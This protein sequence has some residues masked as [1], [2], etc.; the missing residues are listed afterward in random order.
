MNARKKSNR[1]EPAQTTS[2]LSTRRKEILNILNQQESSWS[3]C[4]LDYCGNHTPDTEL[5][6]VLVEIGNT[7]S[8]RASTPA[9]TKQAVI[10]ELQRN[11]EYYLNHALPQISLSFSRVLAD[12]PE[13]FSL[14]LCH[15]LYE[16]FEKALIEHIREEEHDFQAFN[17]GTKAG[18]DCFHA[19]HDETAALDQ[20][21]EMLSECTTSKSFDPCHILVLR[22]Q[23]LS[24]D[25]KI[26]TFV[27]EKLLMPMLK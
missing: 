18:P 27:E 13:H 3:Q 4:V 24:N 16:V 17:K 2:G 6:Q 19:H 7:D 20:I 11:H 8:G 5:L 1:T 15:T 9:L 22:L 12:R 10:A 23:N 25:L 14:H 21:I 26:H